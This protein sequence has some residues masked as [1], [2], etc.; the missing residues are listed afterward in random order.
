MNGTEELPEDAGEATFCKKSQKALS[1]IVMANSTPHI[2]LVTSCEKASLYLKKQYFRKQM[3]KGIGVLISEE[4][5]VVTLLGSLPSSYSTLVTA[6]EA[7]VDELKLDFVQQALIHAMK[8]RSK[9]E[10]LAVTH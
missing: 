5:Q 3:S 1:T 8:N 9:W 10:L 4:D 6:L 7:R 2:Y